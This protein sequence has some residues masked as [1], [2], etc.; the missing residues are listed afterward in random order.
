MFLIFILELDH[1]TIFFQ[2]FG[3]FLIHKVIKDQILE[4][5]F[6]LILQKWLIL[7]IVLKL[8]IKECVF[9]EVLVIGQDRFIHFD[10]KQSNGHTDL[11]FMV[12]CVFFEMRGIDFI[13]A[14]VSN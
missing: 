14:F 4:K 9:Q 11:A 6:F 12:F 2:Y 8:H 7:D 1:F 5:V 13:P 3:T 10:H